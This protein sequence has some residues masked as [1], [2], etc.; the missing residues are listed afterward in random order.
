MDGKQTLT[1]NAWIMAGFRALSKA[2]PGALK[3]EP[4]ARALKVSKGSF[5]WHFKNVDDLKQ[6]MIAH[7]CEVATDAIIAEITRSQQK[8]H[9]A[10]SHLLALS[11]TPPDA[12][13]GG[14]ETE[15][16]IRDWG[17][18]EDFVARAVRQVDRQRVDFVSQLMQQYGLPEH[19]AEQKARQ[20]Y[21]GLIGLEALSL[22]GFDNVAGDLQALLA[23]LLAPFSRG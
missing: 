2:G 13:F 11:V 6:A 14:P 18:Y 19:A 3:A 4:L 12:P 17:R 15:A 16:A 22:S 23:S 7:W 21:A 9:A 5:Y 8:P 20:L 1:R 10:L